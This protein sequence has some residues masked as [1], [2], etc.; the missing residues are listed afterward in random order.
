MVNKILDSIVLDYLLKNVILAT[1]SI[2]KEA[3]IELETNVVIFEVIFNMQPEKVIN[4]LHLVIIKVK[5]YFGTSFMIEVG[6]LNY[7]TTWL[8]ILNFS[9]FPAIH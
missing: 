2:I 7:F 1:D 8:V 4:K 5:G 9:Y 6:L 3:S